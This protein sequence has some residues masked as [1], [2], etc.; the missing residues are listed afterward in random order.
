MVTNDGQRAKQ[1]LSCSEWHGVE[2][3]QEF[4][5][6]MTAAKPWGAPASQVTPEGGPIF[7]IDGVRAWGMLEL[8]QVTN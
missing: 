7:Q 8:G 6:P 3:A 1:Q 5:L 2:A 4:P